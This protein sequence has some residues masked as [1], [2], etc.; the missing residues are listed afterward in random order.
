M[1]ECD[2]RV[3]RTMTKERVHT[4]GELW[5]ALCLNISAESSLANGA[6]ENNF[7]FPSPNPTSLPDL[8][9][10]L[11]KRKRESETQLTSHFI[12]LKENHFLEQMLYGP[13]NNLLSHPMF[14]YV[15]S[16]PLPPVFLPF[17]NLKVVLCPQNHP[18]FPLKVINTHNS[19]LFIHLII[20]FK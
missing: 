2:G 16:S 3:T 8:S 11:L 1:E 17:F 15:C 7:H 19:Y 20:H 13:E 4:A 12:P 6:L 5:Q 14:P 10:D 9:S 18:F